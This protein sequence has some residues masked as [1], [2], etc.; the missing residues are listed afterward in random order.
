MTSIYIAMV[1][2]NLRSQNGF[3]LMNITGGIVKVCNGMIFLPR[4]HSKV[5]GIISKSSRTVMM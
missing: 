3:K 1:V 4:S 5:T 2:L